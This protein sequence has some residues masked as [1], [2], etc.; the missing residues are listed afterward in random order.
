MEEQKLR[1]QINVEDMWDLTP[2]FK[3]D[4]EFEKAFQL[5]E[6][7]I[8]DYP[9]QNDTFVNK[10]GELKERLEKLEDLNRKLDKLQTYSHQRSDEDTSN[11]HYQAYVERVSKLESTLSET[12]SYLNPTILK[13]DYNFIQSFYK[14]EPKLEYFDSYFK[15][16]F[17]YQKHYLKENEELLMAKVGRMTGYASE[18]SSILLD[19]DLKYGFV[20]KDG[21]EI[22]LTDSNFR[23]FIL[24][25]NRDVRKD[26]FMKM[27]HTLKQFKNVFANSLAGMVEESN[28]LRMIRN[29]PSNLEASLFDEEIT[30]DVYHN[31]IKTVRDNLSV[32]YDYFSFKKQYL[33]LD[34]FHLYDTGVELVPEY[35]K[36]YSFQE[37]KEIILN[38][39]SIFGEEYVSCVKR[40]FKDHWIDIFPNKGKRGGAYSGGAYDTYPYI[41]LNYNGEYDDVS[42]LIHE[43]GHSMHSYYARKNNPYIT[44]DYKIFVAEVASTVNELLLSHYLYEH[45]E[46]DLEKMYLLNQKLDLYKAT[47]YRQTMFA[48]FEEKFYQA[49][50]NGTVLTSDYLCDT[51]YELVQDYFGPSVV[52]DDEIRYEWERIPHFFYYFYVY[53]YATG[54]SA[55]THIVR[56]ILNKEENAVHDYLEFL[57]VG[58]KLSP[59]DSLKIAGVD[60][61]KPEVI[62]SSILE[63][64]S[65]FEEL[66]KLTEKM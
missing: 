24:D 65:A 59:L 38:V 48:E 46:N 23:K 25:Q 39:L 53:K 27:Y 35:K 33:K 63:F 52:I 57:K 50:E 5:L 15:E 41:L 32:L 45:S 12:T 54:I 37:A 11:N 19:S 9:K 28:T 3:N 62:E 56:R 58:S 7:E 13:K 10:P 16:L 40:A 21:T 4:E 43:M 60:L 26:A 6:E 34:E 2:I 36:N 51:Y 47:L 44:G 8:K 14:V 64:Q 20:H 30:T 49:S 22:E 29:Y 17:R 61:T 55:A 1:S 66:K 18:A 42:T 31:L